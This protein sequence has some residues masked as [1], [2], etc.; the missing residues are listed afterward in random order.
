VGFNLGLARMKD[1]YLLFLFFKLI[2]ALLFP[3]NTG[4]AMS[5]FGRLFH[6]LIWPPCSCSR[7]RGVLDAAT[8]KCRVCLLAPPNDVVNVA[9]FNYLI[10]ETASG[11]HQNTKDHFPD[12]GL[13]RVAR[14][15][16]VKIPK[17]GEKYTKLPLSMYTECP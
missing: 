16:L 1:L 9:L 2:F 12:H 13:T 4:W 8:T 6:K 15:F 7:S 10:V 14:F 3:R 5:I 17:N 11:N